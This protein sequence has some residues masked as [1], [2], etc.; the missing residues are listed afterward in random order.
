MRDLAGLAALFTVGQATPIWLSSLI[1][2]AVTLAV[3][4]YRL[5]RHDGSRRTH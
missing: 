3:I 2:F 1:A 5:R 4:S